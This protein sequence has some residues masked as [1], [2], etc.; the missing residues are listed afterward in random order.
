MV[1]G[2]KLDIKSHKWFSGDWDWDELE[3]RS[4]TP[5]Y[6]PVVAGEN[7]T[8]NFASYPDS[9]KEPDEVAAEDDPFQIW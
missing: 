7:D 4:M 9:P 8:S 2:G 5:F 6:C 3:D 1:K